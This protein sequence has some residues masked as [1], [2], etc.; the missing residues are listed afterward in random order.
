[1]HER[2]IRKA[3]RKMIW[4][5][6]WRGLTFRSLPSASEQLARFWEEVTKQKR[7]EGKEHDER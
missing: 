4:G 5:S 6:F 3:Q 7:N 2:A 1:M